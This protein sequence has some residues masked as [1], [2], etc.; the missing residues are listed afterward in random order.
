MILSQTD[1]DPDIVRLLSGKGERSIN[2]LFRVIERVGLCKTP[3]PGNRAGYV[4]HLQCEEPWAVHAAKDVAAWLAAPGTIDKLTWELISA[5]MHAGLQ[6]L[7]LPPRS[8]GPPMLWWEP[9]K[10]GRL[11]HN[12][13]DILC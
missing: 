8:H 2:D 11:M 4:A 6:C 7:N 1:L 10:E 5:T 3:D 12:I 9:S 13:C